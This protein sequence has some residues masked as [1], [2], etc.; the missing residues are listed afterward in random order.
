MARLV[1]YETYRCDI[2]RYISPAWVNPTNFHHNLCQACDKDVTRAE[3]LLWIVKQAE[4]ARR[5]LT[6]TPSV[7]EPARQ[8]LTSNPSGP[9]SH[10]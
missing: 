9:D 10:E 5:F 2:C 8:P 7:F 6:E 4:K 3:R 1:E